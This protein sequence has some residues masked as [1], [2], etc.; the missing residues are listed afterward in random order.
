MDVSFS[1]LG[2]SHKVQVEPEHGLEFIRPVET[3]AGVHGH[4]ARHILRDGD[5]N[6]HGEVYN[7]ERF[8]LWFEPVRQARCRSITRR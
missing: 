3:H 4:S 7:I 1:G 2:S 6:Y 5:V 8:D